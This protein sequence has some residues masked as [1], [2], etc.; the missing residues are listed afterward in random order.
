M[1]IDEILN[2]F[3]QRKGYFPKE[4]VVAAI[5]QKEAI[6]PYL[7]EDLQRLADAGDAVDQE[8]NSGLSLFSLFLLSQFRETRAYPLIVA[9]AATEPETVEILFGDITCMGLNQ[10][11]ASVYDGDLTPIQSLIEDDDNSQYV[12][13]SAIEAMAPLY[14][15]GQLTRETILDY[16]TQLYRGKLT[17]EYSQVWNALVACTEAFGFI[18]LLDEMN[19]A[20]SNDLTEPYYYQDNCLE[21]LLLEHSGEPLFRRIKTSLIDDTVAELQDWAT[22]RPEPKPNRRNDAIPESRFIHTDGTLVRETP[23]TGRNDPCPCGS[24]K[25][26]KKCC[27]R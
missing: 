25:K 13:G 11:L 6:T 20:F 23:K 18:E 10:I 14:Q 24:G 16:F 22:F 12:R 27:G 4:A 2:E 19:K 1:T 15:S 5:E 8:D 26:F 17:R 21:N 9:M 7:L 3:A